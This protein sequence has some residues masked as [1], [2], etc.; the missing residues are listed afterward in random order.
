MHTNGHLCRIVAGIHQND[1]VRPVLGH[2]AN[3][4]APLRRIFLFPFRPCIHFPDF[5]LFLCIG[6]R[7]FLR[8]IRCLR[9]FLRYRLFVRLGYRHVLRQSKE[10]IRSL[11]ENL[12]Q[13]RQ[14]EDVR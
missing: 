14:D 6:L 4:Y 11:P 1:R 12:R 8:H 13:L 2:A 9:F 3:I 7:G 5:L 10:V